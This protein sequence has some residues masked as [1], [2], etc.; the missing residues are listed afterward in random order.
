MTQG[1][2]KNCSDLS[3]TSTCANTQLVVYAYVWHNPANHK[4]SFEASDMHSRSYLRY[5]R[6]APRI[7]RSAIFPET[8]PLTA[9]LRT[10]LMP[11]VPT[12]HRRPAA[13][14]FHYSHSNLKQKAKSEEKQPTNISDFDVLGSVPVPSTSVD[15]CMYD[16]FGLNSGITIDGGDGAL[17][18]NGEAFRWRPWEAIG[19]KTLVNKKGQFEL[20]EE[21]LQVFDALWPR[22]GMLSPSRTC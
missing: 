9:P 12:Y 1:N 10:T 13:R 19:E 21:S 22:P 17:L 16:G 7:L 18:V 20:P 4:D 5:Q 3:S 15:V 14:P 8:A 11:A 6:H 2:Q